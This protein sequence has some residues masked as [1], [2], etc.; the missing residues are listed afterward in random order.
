MPRHCIGLTFFLVLILTGGAAGQHVMATISVGNAPLDLVYDSINNKI[1]VANEG[2]NTV[3]VIDP[4]DNR[5]TATIPVGEHPGAICWNA[6]NGKVY[7]ANN[8]LAQGGTVTIIDAGGDSVIT[9]VPVGNGPADILWNPTQ[10]K[11]YCMCRDNATVTVIDGAGDGVITSVG[12]GQTLNEILYNP[13]ND[14]CYVSSGAFQQPGKVYVIDC[15]DDVFLFDFNSGSNA[16]AMAHNPTNNRLY[17]ANIGSG[18]MS[19]IDGNNH[20]NL[21]MLS[22]GEE[23]RDVVWTP[24]NRVFVS[25]Y[26]GQKVWSMH[27]DSLRFR[28]TAGITGNPHSLL[29]VPHTQKLFVTMPLQSQVVVIDARPGHESRVIDYINVGSGPVPLALYPAESQV[30]VGNSWGN[31]VTV[32]K[33]VIGIEERPA[34][35]TQAWAAVQAQPNPAPAGG[36]VLFSVNGFVPGRLEIWNA[37]GQLVTGTP[38][39]GN[40]TV[41]APTASGLYLYRFSSGNRAVTGKLIV[42]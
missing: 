20:S 33:D 22:T 9:T 36:P 17:I 8:I 1:F 37:A 23:P 14:Y 34:G 39:A 12:L 30:Y 15:A 11:V 29:Y 16:Y 4:D 31:T 27:G 7:T 24:D 2:M 41:P 21:R 40:L 10:N 6:T 18:N 35:G 13:T 5:V 25:S 42:E 3:S 32:I 19:V 38:A 28:S 26:W